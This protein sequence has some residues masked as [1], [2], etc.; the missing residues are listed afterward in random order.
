MNHTSTQRK[1]RTHACCIHFDVCRQLVKQFRMCTKRIISNFHEKFRRL[2]NDLSRTE[3][4]TDYT[5]LCPSVRVS[6]KTRTRC[7]DTCVQFWFG[8]SRQQQTTSSELIIQNSNRQYCQGQKDWS[9]TPRPI[10]IADYQN[11]QQPF[12]HNT[13]TFERYLCEKKTNIV[14][15]H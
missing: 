14:R 8:Q 5:M 15:L 2:P 12:S 11:H 13:T 4:Y 6:M 10:P 9:T 1:L 7:Y 3:R